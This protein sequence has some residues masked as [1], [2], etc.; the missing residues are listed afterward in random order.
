MKYL[1][2]NETFGLKGR[3]SSHSMPLNPKSARVFILIVLWYLN[4]FTYSEKT[5]NGLIEGLPY[6]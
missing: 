4:I 1:L 3:R 5:A 2:N 6:L